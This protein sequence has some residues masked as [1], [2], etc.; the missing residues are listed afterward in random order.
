MAPVVSTLERH[1][2]ALSTT[3][4][5]PHERAFQRTTGRALRR[6][7]A[8]FRSPGS[9]SNGSSSFEACWE[10]LRELQRSLSATLRAAPTL[11]LPSIS[12]V[13]AALRGTLIP[14]PGLQADVPLPEPKLPPA[15]AAAGE[16]P[17]GGPAE[18][19]RL[20]VRIER[21]GEQAE[22]GGLATC[23][24]APLSTRSSCS[25]QPFPCLPAVP[26]GR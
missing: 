24:P 15:A 23:R 12:P 18:D 20:G 16:A 11:S 7:I 5:T 6:A 9:S 22:I 8:T 3:A 17:A 19:E 10:P 21:F 1:D 26:I 13:L 4:S 2:R 14:M 25:A